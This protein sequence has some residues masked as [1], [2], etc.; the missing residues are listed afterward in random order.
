VRSIESF[1]NSG[2]VYNTTFFPRMFQ[3]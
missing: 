3:R 2:N 1:S